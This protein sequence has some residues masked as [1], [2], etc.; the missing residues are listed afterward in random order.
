MD[1]FGPVEDVGD[2]DFVGDFRGTLLS[3]WMRWYFRKSLKMDISLINI[4]IKII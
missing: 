1:F 4:I 2:V 3:E